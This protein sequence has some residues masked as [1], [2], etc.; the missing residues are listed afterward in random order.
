MIGRGRRTVPVFSSG[1]AIEAGRREGELWLEAMKTQRPWVGFDLDGT[2]ARHEGWRGHGEIGET[3]PSVVALA[4][5]ALDAG[6]RIKIVTARVSPESMMLAGVE[7]GDALKPI[8]DWCAENLGGRT[9]DVTCRKDPWCVMLV[10]DVAQ[11]VE[12]N[13]GLGEREAERLLKRMEKWGLGW[14]SG[15]DGV[16]TVKARPDGAGVKTARRKSVSRGK[17]ETDSAGR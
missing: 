13:D 4:N 1:L 5:A 16:L 17:S 15:S 8:Q 9:P 11:G 10:D 2:L 12:R 7:Y 14:K 6:V 3:V